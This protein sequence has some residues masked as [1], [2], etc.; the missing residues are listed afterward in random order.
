MAEERTA[1]QAKADNI[2]KMGPE[3]GEVYSAL[4]QETA[5]L[6]IRWFEFLELFATKPSRIDLLN[7]A[8]PRFFRTV[9]DV[10]FEAVVLHVARM[11]DPPKSAGKENL[12]LQAV[13]ELRRTRPSTSL[14]TMPSLNPRLPENG[15]TGC[16]PIV[17]ASTP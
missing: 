7:R 10:L 13:V 1:A 16:S 2:A 11:V 8:A 15:A 5:L 4:W 12:S 9:Q 14:L 17:T 6:S 3:L